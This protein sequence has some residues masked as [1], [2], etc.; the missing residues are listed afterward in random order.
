VF[1]AL[2]ALVLLVACVNVANL[3]LVR[4]TARSRELALRVAVGA[5]RLR[6]LR[7]LLVESLLLSTLG[8]LAGAGIGRGL[9][10]LLA[11]IEM[12]SVPIHFDFGFDW[13][14]FAVVAACVLGAALASGL[15]PALRAARTDPIAGL[16]DGRAP[17]GAGRQRLRDLLVVGQVA[18]CAVLLIVAGLF[19][20]S[21][22]AARGMDLGFRPD[23][24]VDA[25]IDVAQIG[26]DEVRGRAF[27]ETLVQRVAAL[28]GVEAV[29]TAYSVP[30]GYYSKSTRVERA[31]AEALRESDAPHVRTNSVSPSY[32]PVLGIPILKG[33]G[34]SERDSAGAA[35]VAIVNERLAARLWPGQDPIGQRLV[36]RLP[37]RAPAEV[38]GVAR[39]AKYGSLLEDPQPHLYLPESQSYESLRVLHV[40]T[41]L[42]PASVVAAIESE[43]QRLQPSLPVF[44][45]GTLAQSLEGPNGFFL[46]RTGT[47]LVTALGGLGLLLAAVGV[48]GVVSYVVALRTHEIGIRRALGASPRDVMGL[49]LGHGL[50]LV[51]LGLVGGSLLAVSLGRALSGLIYGVTPHDPAVLAGVALVLATTALAACLHP[52]WRALRIEPTSALRCE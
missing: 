2:V 47:L 26:L 13:R 37:D 15:V 23:S 32:F 42:P 1:G 17:A 8:G 38:V 4:T 45:G 28:P 3:L 12:P 10:G 19:G 29:A 20:R 41:R 24:I 5:S 7:Q 33:R 49:V 11:R 35:P 44:D 30:L 18:G 36:F 48:S 16:R 27:Q 6:L 40:R 14:V 9:S 34:F 25:S 21:L 31:G 50:R 39:D 22:Q 52:T 46:L 51:G 43:V